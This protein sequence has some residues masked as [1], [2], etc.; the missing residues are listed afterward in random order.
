MFDSFEYISQHLPEAK[1]LQEEDIL[2]RQ[3]RLCISLL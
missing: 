3:M 1:F 2:R